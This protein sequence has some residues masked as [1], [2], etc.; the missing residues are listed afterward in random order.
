VR[1]GEGCDT[2]DGVALCSVIGFAHGV[3]DDEEALGAVDEV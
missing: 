2:D 3:L 1:E